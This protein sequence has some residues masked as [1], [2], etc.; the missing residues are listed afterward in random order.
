VIDLEAQP[1]VIDK[2][3]RRRARRLRVSLTGKLVAVPP[4]GSNNAKTERFYN[5]NGSVVVLKIDGKKVTKVGEVEVRGLPEGEGVFVG[6]LRTTISGAAC[7]RRH[8]HQ[9]WHVVETAA[10]RRRCGRTQ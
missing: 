1:R 6:T 8:R 7:R 4:R 10:S 2:V 3:G 9:Y 5:R